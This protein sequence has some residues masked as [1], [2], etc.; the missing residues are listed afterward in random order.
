MDIDSQFIDQKENL[1]IIVHAISGSLAAAL[2]TFITYP[3]EKIKTQ[4]QIV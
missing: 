3:I 4:M 1:Y 2:S